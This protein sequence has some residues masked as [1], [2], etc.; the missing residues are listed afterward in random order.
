M[1]AEMLRSIV[2]GGVDIENDRFD[3]ISEHQWLAGSCSEA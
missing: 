2:D 3:S 1:V